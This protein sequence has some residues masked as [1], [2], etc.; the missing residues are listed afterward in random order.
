M[1]DED[2]FADELRYIN[3]YTDDLKQMRGL[4]KQE[5][6]TD[7]VTQRAYVAEPHPSVYRYSSAHSFV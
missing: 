6:L 7:M 1:V 5:Y 2:I 4:S 3:Q